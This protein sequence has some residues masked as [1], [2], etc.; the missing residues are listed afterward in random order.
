VDVDLQGASVISV[1][2][3]VF[4]ATG[5]WFGAVWPWWQKRAAHPEVRLEQINYP[6]KQQWRTDQRAIIVNHG[7]ATMRHVTIR[8]IGEDG[9][10]HTEGGLW[11]PMPIPEI[12]AGQA[13]HLPLGM[14]LGEASL[15]S[16]VLTWRDRRVGTQQRTFWVTWQRVT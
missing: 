4:S 7:P 13:L 5:L 6:D 8:L 15:R 14:L 2:A 16:A 3:L 12:H 9:H 11:P 1:V 10:E